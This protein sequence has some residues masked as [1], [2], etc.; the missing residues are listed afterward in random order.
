MEELLENYQNAMENNQ[1]FVFNIKD[2]FSFGLLKDGFS[3]Q[4]KLSVV[5]KYAKE[6]GYIRISDNKVT[7]TKKGQREAKKTK[8]TW[9]PSIH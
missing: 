7:L 5:K 3:D 4:E 6:S 9:D 8:H 1:P 2:F